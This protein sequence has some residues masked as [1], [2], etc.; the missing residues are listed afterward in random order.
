MTCKKACLVILGMVLLSGCTLFMPP[1][2]ELGV[3]FEDT[4]DGATADW[5]TYEDANQHWWI[6]GGQYNILVKVPHQPMTSWRTQIG[7]FHNFRLDIDAEQLN[8]PDD[9]TYGVLFRVIDDDNYYCFYITGNSYVGLKKKVA[10]Q[11]VVLLPELLSYYVNWG[12]DANHLTVIAEG[13]QLE[14]FV[15]GQSHFTVTDTEFAAGGIG[16]MAEM[17]TSPG[18]THI[19]FDNIVLQELP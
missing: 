13:N 12:N 7:A 18:Q 1:S 3:L 15:N 9:N 8:G 16:M 14:V 5:L 11:F 6:E 19:V 17:R 10:G 4:F 2:M